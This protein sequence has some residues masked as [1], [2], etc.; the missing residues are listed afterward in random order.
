MA[1]AK[2]RIFPGKRQGHHSAPTITAPQASAATF[3]HGAPVKFSTGNLVAVS[4]VSAGSILYV[5][6]SST[7]NI[8]GF[9]AGKAL[10]SSTKSIVAHT[11][12]EGVT[13]VG[14]LIQTAAS[15]SS[16]VAT[17][18]NIGSYAYLAKISGDTHWGF[19]LN[20]PGASSA[21]YVRGILL[22][23]IDPASTV[24]GRVTVQIT[25]GGLLHENA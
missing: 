17:A 22:D 10:A 11:I 3:A 23:L 13:F 19:T 6:T 24:N 18:A 8:L 7:A 2:I 1:Q 21:N 15:A 25:N 20:T 9:A 16:A 4:T 12:A 14:N 5:K